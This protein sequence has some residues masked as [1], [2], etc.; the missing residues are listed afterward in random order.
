MKKQKECVAMLL[1]GG[2]GSRLQPLTQHLAKPAV[3]FGGKYRIVDF[4][5]SNCA[6]SGIDTVGVL[7]Q[8]QPLLLNEYI[9]NGQPWD[10]DRNYGGV[11]ILPPYKA[12][13]GG[14]WYHGTANAVWQNREFIERYHPKYVLVLSGDH[15]YRMNYRALIARHRECGADATIAVIDVPIGEASRFGI[16]T[17][18][19][20]GMITDFEEKPKNPK[21]TLASMGIYVFNT[22]Y[23]FRYLAAD[24]ADKASKNDFGKNVIPAMLAGG[25]RLAAYR[26]EGYWRDVGTLESLWQANMD[27]TGEH[28]AFDL[29]WGNG[30]IF[31]RSDGSTPQYV[32]EGGSVQECI[33]S[34]GCRILG[35]V[36]RSVLSPNVVV[37]RGAVV[38]DSVLL[39][40]VRVGKNAHVEYSILDENVTVSEGAMLGSSRE[41]RELTVIGREGSV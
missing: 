40:G 7:T 21:S 27:L 36:E 19:A 5:L 4:T 39:N 20:Q 34:Q 28:P 15:I 24:E 29:F 13:K 32:G 11:Q 14:D 38:K 8:Y 18:D 41:K 30:R 1:A 37:E 3:P 17:A 10:L 23:L 9:G 6:N 26:F 31:S 33:L 22:E 2:E 35:R 12:K 25:G 16:L